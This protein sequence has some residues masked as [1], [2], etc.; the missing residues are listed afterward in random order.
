MYVDIPI[1]MQDT[2]VQFEF[3][4]EI[5]RCRGTVTLFSADNLAAWAVG[6]FKALASTF[7]RCQ[8]CM[9]THD[10]MQAKVYLQIL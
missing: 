9:V 5:V 6:G 1:K 10:E 2:G 3:D 4:G 7:R 8:F